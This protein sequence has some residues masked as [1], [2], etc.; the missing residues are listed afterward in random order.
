[1]TTKLIG[2]RQHPNVSGPMVIAS[3]ILRTDRTTWFRPRQID[4]ALPQIK[5]LQSLRQMYV[6]EMTITEEYG[7]MEIGLVL[8]NDYQHSTEKYT[9]DGVELTDYVQYFDPAGLSEE[10]DSIMNLVNRGVVTMTTR[11][12]QEATDIN[13]QFDSVVWPT[14]TAKRYD[15]VIGV[16]AS[17]TDGVFGQT[18]QFLDKDDNPVPFRGTTFV[19]SSTPGTTLQFMIDNISNFTDL[20]DGETLFVVHGGGNDCT[21][22]TSAGGTG[23]SASGTVIGWNDIPEIHRT[24]TLARY[25]ELVTELKKHGDV[26]LT[27]VSFRDY[28]GQPLQLDDPDS[29]GTGSWNENVV[30]SMIKELTPDWWDWPND[31]PVLD[32]YSLSR[33]NPEILDDDNVHQ[34]DDATYAGDPDSGYPPGPGYY[35]LRNY[36]VT[37][38][39][40]RD[41]IQPAPYDHTIYRDRILLNV[42]VENALIGRPSFQR[43]AVQQPL[44]NNTDVV[45]PLISFQSP[46]TPVAS[47]HITMPSRSF[48]RS[49]LATR[50]LPWDEGCL[51]SNVLAHSRGSADPMTFVFSSVGR[52]GTVCISGLFTVGPQDDNRKAKVTL[53]DKDGDKTAEYENSD[54]LTST[55]DHAYMTTLDYELDSDEDTLTIVVEGADGATAGYVGAIVLDIKH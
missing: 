2:L 52:S 40:N 37:T 51:D 20:V 53:T 24:E 27:S 49:N 36:L 32:Y 9:V 14:Y 35:S 8:T 6:E 19:S 17:I 43:W 42:G 23:D 55:E 41:A 47:V 44:E 13:N 11:V 28:K 5:R 45:T 54:P 33:Y 18:R 46:E 10:L 3:S 50:D 15:T 21:T 31:R 30:Y 25:R 39:A 38:L 48:G 7:L 29:V 4:D 16:G 1:M 26:A 22:L 12:D 34:D